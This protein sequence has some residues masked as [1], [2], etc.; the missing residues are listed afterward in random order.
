MKCLKV[1]VLLDNSLLCIQA[2]YFR[3]STQYREFNVTLEG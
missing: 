3:P 2:K 1:N